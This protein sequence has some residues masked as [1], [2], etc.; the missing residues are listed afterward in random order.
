MLC[1]AAVLGENVSVVSLRQCIEAGFFINLHVNFLNKYKV[2]QQT[3]RA[4]CIAG[5]IHSIAQTSRTNKNAGKTKAQNWWC[6]AVMA[7]TACR[8][9]NKRIL[10]IKKGRVSTRTKDS[11]LCI[12]R[13]MQGIYNVQRNRGEEMEQKE[14]KQKWSAA[15]A[16][17]CKDEWVV[18]RDSFHLTS[19]FES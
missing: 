14:V 17:G 16:K 18:S 13:A 6:S 3:W 15:L 19:M 12:K 9:S 5:P 8:S 7:G 4:E 1:I 10:L 2:V 11:E